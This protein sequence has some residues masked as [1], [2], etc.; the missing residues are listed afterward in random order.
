MKNS[1]T[2]LYNTNLITNGTTRKERSKNLKTIDAICGA[3]I[4]SGN[5][6][7]LTYLIQKFGEK[8]GSAYWNDLLQI[9]SSKGSPSKGRNTMWWMRLLSAL[10]LNSYEKVKRFNANLAEYLAFKYHLGGSKNILLQ[11]DTLE[12]LREL[13]SQAVK[14]NDHH[15]LLDWQRRCLRFFE[16]EKDKVGYLK[17]WLLEDEKRHFETVLFEQGAKELL[18]KGAATVSEESITPQSLFQILLRHP[19]ES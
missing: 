18:R 3:G 7:L 11:E 6:Q 19:Q 10:E 2:W 17:G 1:L 12:P 16:Q 9:A 14:N 15:A 8:V 13:G 4:H 5:I